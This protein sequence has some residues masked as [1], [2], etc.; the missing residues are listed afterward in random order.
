MLLVTVNVGDETVTLA[1]VA[2]NSPMLIVKS[3]STFSSTAGPVPV[4]SPTSAS[5]KMF[6]I[7]R[8]NVSAEFVALTVQ[9]FSA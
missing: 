8:V 2:L 7:V 9:V 6:S 1:L 3:L 5:L 4:W